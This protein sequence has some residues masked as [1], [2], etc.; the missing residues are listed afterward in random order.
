MPK[1]TTLEILIRG[2]ERI[3]DGWCQGSLWTDT[4]GVDCDLNRAACYCAL[5]AITEVEVDSEHDAYCILVGQL[6]GDRLSDW[7]D[8]PDRTKQEVLDLFT[9]AIHECS[10]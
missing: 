5:G 1:M 8:D 7:N 4:E 9:R 3:K 10:L 2:K 6:G